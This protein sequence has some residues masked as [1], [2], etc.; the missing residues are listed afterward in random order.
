[1]TSA[2]TLLEL[3]NEGLWHSAFRTGRFTTTVTVTMTVALIA[4]V[5]A[6]VT[7]T[8]AAAAN[9]DCRTMGEQSSSSS[10]ASWLGP[11]LEATSSNSR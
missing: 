9:C 4:T 3:L 5:I 11:A 7:V 6:T 2:V 1:M 10:H 8:V